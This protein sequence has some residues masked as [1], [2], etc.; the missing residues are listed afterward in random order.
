M[1]IFFIFFVVVSLKN[2]PKIANRKNIR[3]RL[4]HYVLLSKI[5]KFKKRCSI[6]KKSTESYAFRKKVVYLPKMRNTL[7]LKYNLWK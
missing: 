2:V 7:F 5:K 4:F 1:V 6:P 3:R